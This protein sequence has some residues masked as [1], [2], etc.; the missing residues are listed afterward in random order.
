MKYLWK[1][2]ICALAAFFILSLP[3]AYAK[4]SGHSGNGGAKNPAGFS[5]PRWTQGEKTGWHGADRPPGL[6]KRVNAAGEYVDK[7]KKEEKEKK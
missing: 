6:M 4:H 5:P 2:L 3:S 7:E 1:G